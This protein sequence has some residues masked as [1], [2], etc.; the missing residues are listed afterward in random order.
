MASREYAIFKI[1]S[2]ASVRWLLGQL[3]QP[4]SLIPVAAHS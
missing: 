4:R 1:D 2:I 3:G